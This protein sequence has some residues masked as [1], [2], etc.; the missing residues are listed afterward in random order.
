MTRTIGLMSGKGGVGKTTITSNLSTILAKKEKKVTVLDCNF[1]TSHLLMHFGKVYHP[2]TLNDVL[3]G[4]SS[5][6]EAT[7]LNYTGVRVVPASLDLSDMMGVDVKMLGSKIENIFQD[8][9][10]V[11]LDNA[12]GF[13]RESISGMMA[14]NEAILV[15][16]PYLPDITDI[17]RGKTILEDLGVDILGVVL[18][19]VTGKKFEL[20]DE[21]ILELIELPILAKI[22]F[23]YKVME[24]LGLKTPLT[25]YDKKSRVSK[26]L[27]RLASTL[28]GD[29]YIPAGG[30]ILN[31][32][33]A[34]V[35]RW[36]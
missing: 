8:Q 3:K 35:K 25:F 5:M 28:A 16:T 9:D 34:L 30:G 17:I 29:N 22:P 14:S 4:E 10:F 6:D 36:S 7:Y 2:K 23:D 33:S 1:T 12:A 13:G 27:H 21:E 31:T 26:E 11:F 20:P 32:L 19:K 15:A 24:S 18:N